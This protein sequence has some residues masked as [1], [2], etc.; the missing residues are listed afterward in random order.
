MI[1]GTMSPL[2][3][4]LCSALLCA[5]IAAFGAGWES[6]PRAFVTLRDADPAALVAFDERLE[7]AGGHASVIDA[8]GAAIVYADD[9]V[10][11]RAEIAGAV[12]AVFRSDVE[13]GALAALDPGRRVAGAAWNFARTLD[14]LDPGLETPG[15]PS[16]PRP[17]DAGRRPVLLSR[18][19]G[20][21]Q[22]DAYTHAPYGS[23]Y[24]DTSEFLAGRVA[25]GVWLF[26]DAGPG[27]NWTSNE[28][29]QTLG[30]V[31]AG[32]DNWVRKGGAPAFLTF[33]VETHTNVPVSGTPIQSPMSM[34]VT[35]VN[36]ALGNLG[37]TGADGFE[38]CFAY[39]RSIRDVFAANWCYSIFIA[40]S[41]PNVNQGLFSGG[42]YA[43]AYYG[44]PWVY[45]AR[46]STWAYNYMRY[47][48]VVPMHETGHTFMDTDE[49]DG[50]TQYG[51][52]LNAPD[53]DF[54]Q[55]IMN[56]NDSSRVC[57]ET[58]NQLG[59][60]DLDADGVI[61]PLDVP[62]GTSLTPV[63][64]D[65]TTNPAPTWSGRA[66]VATLG[67]LNPLSNYF[68]PHDQTIAR[69]TAV[70]CRADGGPWAAAIAS[71]GAFDAYGEDFTWTPSP[72]APG[73]HVIE[74]RARTT[75]GVWSTVYAS[76]TLTVA[77]N[78]AVGEPGR[79]GAVLALLPPEPNPAVE[80]ATL[81]F[82]L[83]EA[84]RVRLTI[85]GVDGRRVRVL[86][87]VDRPAGP[88]RLAWDGRDDSGRRAPPGVY[89]C[90]I[91]SHAAS[92]SRRLAVVR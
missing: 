21:T 91:E 13:A 43:W 69:I 20:P 18:R 40:D 82:A 66:A 62:P 23:D 79:A 88:G 78:V 73:T 42:G 76:D 30:G 25:V 8:S 54:A 90:R 65:P 48:A 77:Q 86:L 58:R 64:P 3:L 27:F 53:H 2:R 10:L 52:Y 9:A 56:Q 72:L 70:E 92:A 87:D 57:P 45:M 6:A 26:D 51:G 80:G 84:G 67:N 33:F 59:W 16:G 28:I 68:P 36:E 81:R 31:Q 89:V 22:L 71:D 12:A 17:P 4:A 34:D 37:W 55:C 11:V 19:S 24:Y 7:A 14:A 38:K 32:L 5:P 74:A 1:P 44:G 83:P 35:W 39:N 41:N 47:Y 50:A 29:T 63:I 85:A 61:E 15:G 49:Y 46:Y 75:V 60:R